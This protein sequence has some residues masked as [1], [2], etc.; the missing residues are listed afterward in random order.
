[1]PNMQSI[2][3]NNDHPGSYQH[4]A[5]TARR[6]NGDLHSF[7]NNKVRLRPVQFTRPPAGKLNDSV[8]RPDED[9]DDGQ[10]KES[11]KDGEFP[12]AEMWR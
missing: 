10:R 3:G 4:H 9:G 1:M 11:H 7:Q 5:Q 6:E 2:H 8:D 12:H